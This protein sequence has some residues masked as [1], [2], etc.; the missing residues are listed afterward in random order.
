MKHLKLFAAV[1]VLALTFNFTQAQEKLKLENSVLWK[2]E[3]SDLNEPSYILGTLHFMCEDDFSILE[4]VTNALQSVDALVLE[5]NL[6]NPVEMQ[7]MQES[8]SS[9]KKISEEL[10]K[11]QYNELDKLVTKITGVALDNYDAYGLSIL[12][13][14]INSDNFRKS[15][16]AFSNGNIYP[17]DGLSG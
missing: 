15:F 14:I 12:N 6:S 8:L 7:A 10:S 17:R 4:K 3:R 16:A 1:V 2:I 11:E 5:V 9:S 13:S